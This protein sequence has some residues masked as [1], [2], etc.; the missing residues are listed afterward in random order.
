M[1]GC[2]PGDIHLLQVVDNI[3]FGVNCLTVSIINV[4]FSHILA[5]DIEKRVCR[6]RENHHVCC[7]NGRN[8]VVV[9]HGEDEVHGAVAARLCRAGKVIR[10]SANFFR[11]DLEITEGV[12]VLTHRR[13]VN[14]DVERRVDGEMQRHHRVTTVDIRED[15]CVVAGFREGITV[16]RVSVASHICEIGAVN[17]QYR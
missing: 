2:I 1:T 5:F 12:F 8:A 15:P 4:N 13:V 7:F 3:F 10:E 9:Q 16:P 14:G 11:R 17:A 6:V